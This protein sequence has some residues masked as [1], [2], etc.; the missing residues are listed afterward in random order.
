LKNCCLLRAERKVE[1]FKIYR[2]N[3]IGSFLEEKTMITR[4]SI[5]ALTAGAVALAGTVFTGTVSAYAQEKSTVY[6]TPGL[7][8]PFWRY[9]SKGVEK[10]ATE[11]GY[12]FQ[13][14]ASA[15]SA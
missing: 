1:A 14:L 4:R 3:K 6:L 12:S 9:L 15:N 5:L 10:V 11:N 8:L 13:A 2:A 7:D